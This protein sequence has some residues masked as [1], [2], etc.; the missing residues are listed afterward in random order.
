MFCSTRSF[1]AVLMPGYP[2]SL[3]TCCPRAGARKHPRRRTCAEIA[4]RGSKVGPCVPIT[5]ISRDT[6]GPTGTRRRC[7]RYEN[8]RR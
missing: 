2:P 3:L 7:E 5:R 1:R 6:R 8:A 4:G